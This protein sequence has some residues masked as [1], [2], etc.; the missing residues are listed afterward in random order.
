MKD[1][2]HI[3]YF[4]VGE[5]TFCY[6]CGF[7]CG[8]YV[9]WSILCPFKRSPKPCSVLNQ[10]WKPQICC[11][12]II[13]LS[14]LTAESIICI[15]S[16]VYFRPMSPSQFLTMFCCWCFSMLQG[17]TNTCFRRSFVRLN[18]LVKQGDAIF[19][20]CWRDENIKNSSFSK[21]QNYCMY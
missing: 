10:T 15:P 12:I 17:K 9:H 2:E 20:N 14:T 8:W 5:L 4:N 19:Y 21:I 6:W 1:L 16:S 11:C 18:N 13:A 7:K 3:S